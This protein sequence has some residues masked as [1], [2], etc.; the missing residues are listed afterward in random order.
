MVRALRLPSFVKSRDPTLLSHR[1]KEAKEA[2]VA[3]LTSYRPRPLERNGVVLVLG[4]ARIASQ[5]VNYGCPSAPNSCLYVKV[6]NF[7]N[8]ECRLS[9]RGEPS[10]LSPAD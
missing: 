6:N 9:C 7:M 1:S 3:F 4:T 2:D 5:P 10:D 8:L